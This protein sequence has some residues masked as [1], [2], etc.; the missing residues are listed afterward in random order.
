MSGASVYERDFYAWATE[1]AA[2]LRARRLSEADI[3]NIAEE[4]EDM[5]S[6]HRTG[7]I[8]RLVEQVR[9]IGTGWV[10]PIDLEP[11]DRQ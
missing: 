7:T 10:V 9:N 2:L 8:A 5:G 3:E 6:L 4:I 11:S 1:Q